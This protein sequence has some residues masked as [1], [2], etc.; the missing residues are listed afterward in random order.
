MRYAANS[1]GQHWLSVK[2]EQIGI[3]FN[4][5]HLPSW[6]ASKAFL[7]ILM[8]SI[9]R[10]IFDEEKI[11]IRLR[12]LN[13]TQRVSIIIRPSNDIEH[14]WSTQ[15]FT[16]PLLLMF[17][18]HPFTVRLRS[19]HKKR[20]DL[21]IEYQNYSE[22]TCVHMNKNCFVHTYPITYIYILHTSVRASPCLLC[23][24]I[25]FYLYVC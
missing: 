6:K 18:A 12:W 9:H 5:R 2:E 15:N 13:S 4:G 16:H 23:A 3:Y 24:Y 7:A 20:R 25:Y 1:Q 21:L 22:S 8:F 11:D 19:K 10:L 14:P 17:L